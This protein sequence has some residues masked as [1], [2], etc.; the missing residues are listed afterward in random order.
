MKKK[1]VL[2][3]FAAIYVCGTVAGIAAMIMQSTKSKPSM[4]EGITSMAGVSPSK[5]II[6]YIN[7]DGPIFFSEGGGNVFTPE[8]GARTWISQLRQAETNAN[9]KAVLLRINSPGGTVGASQELY[10]AVKRV[11]EANKPVI[12][13]VADMAASGGYYTAVAATSIF[14][15]PGSLAGSIGV[16]MSGYDASGLLDKLGIKYAAITSGV[17][18][19]AGTPFK[20]MTAEQRQLMQD[21][22]MN[23]YGQFLNAV[24]DGR[25]KSVD[26]TRPY[27]DGR[28]FTGQ[29]AVEL[30]FADQLGDMYAAEQFIRD[31]YGLKNATLEAISS[32]PPFSFQQL[33]SAVLPGQAPKVQLLPEN[34]FG[35]SPL[36]YLF[37]L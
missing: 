3:A 34:K 2:I 37:Q 35:S 28:V 25:G 16:I 10:N 23:T 5:D 27:A 7:M 18:K 26:E 32:T 13:S 24:A 12:V 11:R 8:R 17:N 29:Q 33:L 19:D 6:G 31:E 4:L 36:L 21:L 30:G 1:V 9:I 15:N 22:I 14:I 20:P